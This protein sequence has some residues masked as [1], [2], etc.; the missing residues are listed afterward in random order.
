MEV[1]LAQ[2]C[3]IRQFRIGSVFAFGLRCGGSEYGIPLV[4]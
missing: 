4:P 1:V 2:R 3:E